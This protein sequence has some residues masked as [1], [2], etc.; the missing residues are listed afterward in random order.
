M[1]QK[2]LPRRYTTLLVISVMIILALILLFIIH[3][4]LG[5]SGLVTPEFNLQAII[6]IFL[7]LIDILVILT[8]IFVLSRYLVKTFFEKRTRRIFTGIKTKLTLA[9]MALAIL[10]IAVFMFL[11]YEVINESVN[12]WFSAPAEEILRQAEN[13]AQEYYELVIE[14]TRRDM[15]QFLA[16]FP[17]GQADAAAV[18]RFR[19]RSG[20]DALMLLDD[21]GRLIWSEKATALPDDILQLDNTRLIQ[22]NVKADEISFYVENH[23][24]ADHVVCFVRYPGP[25]DR[26]LVCIRRIQGSVAYRAFVITEAYQEY[27]Q[28]K[29]QVELIRLNYFIVVGATGIILMF[30]FVWFSL[31]ISKQIIVPVQ[32]LLDG[33]QR[34][35]AGDFSMPIRCD[36]RDEFDVLIG[37][38]NQMMQELQNNKSIIEEASRRLKQVNAE[39][40]NR[41]AFIHSVLNTVAA[42]VVSL[43][44]DLVITVYNDAVRHLLKQRHIQINQTQLKDVVPREKYFELLRLLKETEFYQRVSREVIFR[45]GK[46][47]MHFVVTATLL[48]DYDGRRTGY[49]IVF[50]DVSDLIKTE[51]A[52]AWQEVARRLA[53][54]IKNPLTPI[55]LSMERIRKQFK[56]MKDEDRLPNSS[57]VQQFE[58]LLAESLETTRAET[59]T[60]KYLVEEFSRFARL[61]VPTLRPTD[62]NTLVEDVVRG[63]AGEGNRTLVRMDLAGFLPEI[64]ADAELIRRVIVNL[65]DNAIEAVQEKDTEGLVR[66]TTWYEENGPRILL[67]VEDNGRGIP[68][69]MREHL[70]LPY[71]STKETGMG[72]GLTFVKKILDDHDALIRAENLNRGGCRFTVEF[73]KVRSG[74]H[75]IRPSGT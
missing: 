71:F 45:S 34:V 73:R 32:A 51:K 59:R 14:Q 37:S 23:P 4:H 63:Y 47:E 46:R 18:R 61:P 41:N 64:Y 35:A 15:R 55:Q 68:E 2:K 6:L 54:E 13:L 53:H 25:G 65:V 8:L 72:L 62:L 11:S 42:G 38:F 33:S 49:V 19:D 17:A 70:F 7:T 75:E 5:S 58:Q 74:E 40:E 22:Q 69:E 16:D 28:L 10:P 52:A 30:A 39:L 66:V 12:Q 50:D 60:L 3:Y 20:S 36:A 26:I 31:Y 57:E 67:A 48:Q 56:K 43:N 1:S 29:N 21:A 27:F 44:E 24:E 9:L